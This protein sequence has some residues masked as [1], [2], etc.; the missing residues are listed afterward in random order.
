MARKNK[1]IGNL[2]E[3][4]ACRYLIKNKYKILDRN[5]QKKFDEIDIIA[6]SLDRVLVFIE[7]KTLN[8]NNGLDL[9][10]EDNFTKSKFKR[11][12]RA[13]SLFVNDN[14]RIVDKDR[15][16]RIDLVAILIDG[17][18]GSFEINHYKNVSI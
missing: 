11:I 14:H 13:C 16:W 4:I 18:P 15:G 17:S 9:K 1:E 8:K 5:Y 12:S 2:G 6:K 10:P 7:V 3:D